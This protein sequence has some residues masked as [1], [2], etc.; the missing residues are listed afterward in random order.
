MDSDHGNRATVRFEVRDTGMGIPAEKIPRLFSAFDR[1]HESHESPSQGTG[2]GLAISKHL[3]EAMGGTISVESEPGSGTTF[4]FSHPVEV[5][6]TSWPG[7]FEE[8][9]PCPAEPRGL[10]VDACP[11]RRRVIEKWLEAFECS[12][13]SV[14]ELPAES[15]GFD[16]AIVACEV[17]KDAE[18]AAALQRVL[19]SAETGPPRVIVCTGRGEVLPAEVS[20][21]LSDYQTLERPLKP[22]KLR[23]VL[24]RVV[25]GAHSDDVAVRQQEE[26]SSAEAHGAERDGQRPAEAP[27]PSVLVVDDNPAN[28]LVAKSQ[29]EHLGYAAD[30]VGSGEEA[31]ELLSH[32]A[33]DAMLLDTELSGISGMEVTRRIREGSAATLWPEMPI[34]ALTGAAMEGDR[35]ERLAAGM[36]DYIAKPAGHAD[37]RDALGRWIRPEESR[38]RDVAHRRDTESTIDYTALLGRVS[39]NRETANGV[40]ALIRDRLPLHVENCRK[41]AREHNRG[42]LRRVAHVIA[43]SASM[44][45]ARHLGSLAMDL[46]RDATPE[47]PD[48][49][50]LARKVEELE[51]SARSVEA[52]ISR[53]LE[54]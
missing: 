53:T 30:A 52:E 50:R 29:L 39:N 12:V 23:S 46:E 51:E 10:V 25:H 13:N 4:A 26:G 47:A 16:V 48:F 40:L 31:I 1:V 54:S 17:V 18:A 36:N 32:R 3:V 5:L 28:R 37:L 35:E 2:L 22:S 15:D 11:A 14:A 49:D 19:D 41:A 43:N 7:A 42:T 27:A 21:T 33:Y 44:V 8:E 45:G 9:A 38:E 34:I 6:G 20:E 24:A